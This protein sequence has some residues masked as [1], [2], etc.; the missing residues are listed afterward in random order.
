[1]A[2]GQSPMIIA[3]MDSLSQLGLLHLLPSLIN[4]H[5]AVKTAYF[6]DYVCYF[7]LFN[8]L[9]PSPY[10][11]S[12]LSTVHPLVNHI[13]FTRLSIS[14]RVFLAS[15]DNEVE[16][17]TYSQAFKDVRWRK[18]TTKEIKAL[19]EIETWTIETLLLGKKPIN[20]KWV[21][22]IKLHSD[23]TIVWF[24]A[25]LVAKEY[26]QAEGLDFH[27]TFTLIAKLVTIRCLLVVALARRWELHQFDVQNAIL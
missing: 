6:L 24:K 2:H 27:E 17:T 18:A 11:I 21:F 7:S 14:H 4:S 1:M 13:R 9:H 19:E 23:G 5:Q 16:P 15:L 3:Q 26:T 8:D 25:R 10:I 12:S 20:N 22:K